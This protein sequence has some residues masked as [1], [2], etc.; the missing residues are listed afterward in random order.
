MGP[1]APDHPAINDQCP[2]C[3]IPFRAGDY[4]TLVPIGPGDDLEERAK[5][6]S[7]K[8]YNAIAQVVHWGCA[9]GKLDHQ[10]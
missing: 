10:E 5:A 7:G 8:P 4:V 9:T 2:G 1:L 6:R 3:H